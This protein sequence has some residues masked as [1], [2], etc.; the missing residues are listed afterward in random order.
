MCLHII[1]HVTRT[2]PVKT[3]YR[4]VIFSKFFKTALTET[5]WMLLESQQSL[6]WQ[7]TTSNL[8]CWFWRFSILMIYNTSDAPQAINVN[9]GFCSVPL[10]KEH[11]RFSTS[12]GPPQCVFDISRALTY[13]WCMWGEISNSFFLA[14]RCWICMTAVRYS[15]SQARCH[16]MTQCLLMQSVSGIYHC[17]LCVCAYEKG[18]LLQTAK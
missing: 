9:L 17:A 6:I 18:E 10:G 15:S 11:R 3:P 12:L 7:M 8:T 2:V 16:S 13:G 1:K 14:A 5:V 4:C